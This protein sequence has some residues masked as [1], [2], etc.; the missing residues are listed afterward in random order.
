M[1]TFRSGIILSFLTLLVL[2]GCDSR[3]KRVAVSGKVLIDGE[4][5]TYGTVIFLPKNGRQSTGPLDKSGAFTL[6]CYDANDGALIGTH[7]VEVLAGQAMGSNATKWYAPKKYAD[8][9]ISGLTQEV[10]GAADPVVINLTWKGSPP[11]KPY[12]ERAESDPGEEAFNK[13]RGGKK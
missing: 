8:R 3:P 1:K 4:P 6:T 9:K 13:V 11:E 10:K 12:I 2:S 5:L 7:D